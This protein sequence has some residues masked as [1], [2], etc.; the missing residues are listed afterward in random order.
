MADCEEDIHANNDGIQFRLARQTSPK[1]AKGQTYMHH[2][3]DLYYCH[4]ACGR[5]A[6]FVFHWQALTTSYTSASF[7]ER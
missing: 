6:W 4:R 2:Y 1:E 7:E 3:H 5:L